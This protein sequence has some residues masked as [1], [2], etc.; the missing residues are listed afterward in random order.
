MKKDVLLAFLAG[1]GLVVLIVFALQGALGPQGGALPF[2][3]AHA[4]GGPGAAGNF[5]MVVGHD[6][7]DQH[8]VLYVMDVQAQRVAVYDYK[9]RTMNLMA[10][11]NVRYDLQLDEFRPG[12]QRP[13][14]LDIWRE[15]EGKKEK[16]D[17]DKKKKKKGK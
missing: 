2:P 1:A 10:V 14:P 13:S 5:I 12:S 3:Q 9:N 7:S 6:N 17:K 8:D 15:T 11:R 16:G 4:Q